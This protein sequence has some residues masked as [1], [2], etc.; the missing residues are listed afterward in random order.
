MSW[1][2][3][4]VEKSRHKQLLSDPEVR[5]WY[6]NI[7]RGSIITA[8]VYLR[9]LGL[10]CEKNNTTP[11]VLAEMDEASLTGLTL[12]NVTRL[13]AEDHAGSYIES[14]VKAVKSWLQHNNKQLKGKVRITDAA[15]TPT[16]K[17]ERVPTQEEL[18]KVLRVTEP[19]ARVA[20]CL[21]AHSGLRPEVLG[22]YEGRDGLR[23]GDF[24][25]LEI[26]NKNKT[27]TFSIVPTFL[28]VRK[29]LS[30]GGHQYLTL[31]SEEGA[32]HLKEFLEHRMR[33]G[34]QL[35]P[36]SSVIRP[37]HVRKQFIRTTNIGDKIRGAIR[38]AGFS[39]R[40][41]AL[42][43][44]FDSQL[45]LAESKRFVIR[46]YRV[47]WMGH[48]GDIE[49]EYTL[50]KCLL[51]SELLGDMREAYRRSQQLLVTEGFAHAHEEDITVAFKREL[52]LVSGY[53]KEE[54]ESL[55]LA[56]MDEDEIHR[57]CRESLLGVLLNNGS[58]QRVIAMDDVE[59]HVNEG[60]EYVGRL[61][62]NRAVVRLP[63]A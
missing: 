33:Q 1:H 43:C 24:L 12:D 5:R 18:G 31:C 60:W 51:P 16:L 34:E 53:S 28:R 14:I 15:D 55:D 52:L 61:P 45:L 6:D 63:S 35:S 62:H 25:E 46:D 7:A 17:D 4:S 44:Y 56:G 10:F 57:R 20:I 27:V 38:A 2:R 58:R 42:R 32:N 49:H 19:D 23:L 11:K 54:V 41:Y 50:N 36:E 39:W 29:K 37:R 47:F 40:P 48:K 9:R 13:E 30:K 3:V 22:D 21:I 59:K 26:D 8:D